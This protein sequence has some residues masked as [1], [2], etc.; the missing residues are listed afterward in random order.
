M[1]N[2]LGRG[3]AL[4]ILC[5]SISACG[6]KADPRDPQVVAAEANAAAKNDPNKPAVIAAPPVVLPSDTAT[7]KDTVKAE[8]PGLAPGLKAA[9]KGAKVQPQ[10]S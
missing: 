3:M 10:K 8:T 7:K 9:P 5:L 4:S 6:K 2:A 1:R